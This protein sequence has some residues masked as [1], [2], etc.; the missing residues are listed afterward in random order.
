MLTPTG[1]QVLEFNCRM[2]DPE[3]EA[4][5]TRMDFDL[6]EA[7]E[8]LTIGKLADV[9]ASWNPA[10]SVCVVMASGGYPGEFQVGKRIE[11]LEAA[12]AV[13]GAVLFHA[14][15][16]VEDGSYYTDSGRTLVVS[17]VAGSLQE[18]ARTAYDAVGKIH[19]EGAHYRKDIGIRGSA[20]VRASGE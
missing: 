2:G 19:F 8:A 18:A 15:T 13:P 9:T 11:G 12:D 14:A 20:R 3:T 16:R 1:P 6:A 10:A 5:V 7:L 4:L 17:A